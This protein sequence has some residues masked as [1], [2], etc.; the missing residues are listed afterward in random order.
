MSSKTERRRVSIILSRKKQQV[1][2]FDIRKGNVYLIDK[3]SG[4]IT[5]NH[6]FEKNE[7]FEKTGLVYNNKNML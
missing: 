1:Y 7:S 6:V 5:G 4:Y 2:Y 3:I